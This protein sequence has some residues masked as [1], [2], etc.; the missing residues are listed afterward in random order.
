MVVGGIVVDP[1]TQSPIV[2]LRAVDDSRIYLPIFIGTS[3]A[4]AIAAALADVALP[5]PMTHDLLANILN[6]VGAFVRKVAVTEL[7]E[8]TFYAV[9]TLADDQGHKYEVDARPSDSLALALRTGAKVHV[10]QSVLDAA[11]GVVED[12]APAVPVKAEEAAQQVKDASAGPRAQVAPDIR[13][14]D[15]EEDTFGKYKM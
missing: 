7:I 12:D 14:E 9:I 1:D 6:E 11:G 3:E 15:L 4:T 10:A 8:G 2:V 5:R 13:L